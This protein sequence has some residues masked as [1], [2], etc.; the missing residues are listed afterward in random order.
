MQNHT[1]PT[2]C[3][4]FLPT[5]LAAI[6]LL[7]GC[8]ASESPNGAATGPNQGDWAGTDLQFHLEGGQVSAVKLTRPL[9]CTGANGCKGSVVGPLTGALQLAG[10][11]AAGTLTSKQGSLTLSAQFDT[12][13]LASGTVS[14]ETGGCCTAVAAWS[15][16]WVPGTS[17][18]PS[19]GSGGGAGGTLQGWGD[20]SSGDWHPA[21]SRAVQG[22]LKAP[23]GASAAQQDALAWLEKLR[24]RLGL[25]A[26]AQHT[27][28]NQAAQSHAAFYVAHV[29]Q[30]K[31]TKL[32]PHQQSEAFGAGFSGV[33]PADRTQ[34]AGYPGSNIGEVMAF[35]G[36]VQGA[37]QGWLDT[38]YHRFPL[39]SPGAQSSGYGQAAAGGAKAEVMDV[40]MGGSAAT[41]LVVYPWPGQSGVPASWSG[42]EG[43]QPPPPPSG[44]PSGPVITARFASPVQV[45]A[46]SLLNAQ[47]QAIDHVWLDAGNDKNVAMF[48]AKQT[49]LYAHKPLAAGSYTVRLEVTQNGQPR[50]VQWRFS[51]GN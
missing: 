44:Y 21:K 28:L 11:Q 24:A 46:H 30:Y 9:T 3:A 33:N 32:S 43:P 19:G 17:P 13:A 38:V 40:A 39:V 10:M 49:V 4:T 41:D 18:V 16:A 47:G 48:D 36:S 7:A 8:A 15:A 12:M 20:A 22:T 27:A 51:V 1:I 37:M 2:L 45:T 31:A 50:V 6:A 5:A 35:S 25:P 42:N 26:L 14:A 29:A 23:E 34:A